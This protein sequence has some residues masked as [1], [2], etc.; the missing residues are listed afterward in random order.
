MQVLNTVA[1]YTLENKRSTEGDTQELF[2]FHCI[3]DTKATM[4][5]DFNITN[6]GIKRQA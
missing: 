2:F 4:M 1:M 3:H 6:S 5:N